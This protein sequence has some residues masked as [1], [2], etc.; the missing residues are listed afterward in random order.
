M[1][2]RIAALW[3]LPL[4][5][6]GA[7][8]GAVIVRDEAQLRN[9]I[10]EL[11]P[12]SIVRIAPGNYQPGLS[13]RDVRGTAQK[14]VLIEALDPENPPVFEGGNEAWHLTDVSHFTLR[15][16]VC[17][18]QKNNGINIDDGGSIET[19]SEHVTLDQLHIEDTGPDGNFDAIKCSGVEHL[20]ITACRI[21]GWGG[22]AIDFVGCHH[23]EI[24]DCE[25]TGKPGFSQHT[26]PQF[27]G[28]CSEVWMHHCRLT[29]TGQRPIQ[30]GGSTGL[31]YF[32]PK[33]APYE[34]RAIRV[35]D[36]LI[37][38]GDCAVAFTGAD[39]SSFSHNTIV[40]PEKWIL[41]ILQ[42]TREPRFVRCGDNTFSN[43]LIIFE[44]SK[45][46]AIANIGPDTRAE[47]FTFSRN[48]WFAADAPAQ[49]RP[50][51]PAPETEAVH[52]VDPDLD[53]PDHAPRKNLTAGA[54]PKVTLPLRR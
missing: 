2:P 34:A 28:G 47:S 11:K 21:S 40:R 7:D 23:A 8:P 5:I 54:R 33:D 26:G 51:L 53:G 37:I 22:Q 42:E 16:L 46:A 24:S 20:K 41:R 35:E 15:G 36:N 3:M 48:H 44:R 13:A 10:A 45:V 52:G 43:N 19:P 39:R 38:G 9:A 29:N 14:P 27:K 1:I 18:K 17:R 6:A 12:G 49:S 31:E 4:A 50:D 32:R 25:I 30:I